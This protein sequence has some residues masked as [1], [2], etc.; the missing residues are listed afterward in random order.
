MP[1]LIVLGLALLLV[2]AMTALIASTVFLR[3][4]GPVLE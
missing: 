1:I 2:V 3:T 4:E